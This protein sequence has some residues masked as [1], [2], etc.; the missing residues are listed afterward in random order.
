LKKYVFQAKASITEKF[1]PSFFKGSVPVK[2]GRFLK[3]APQKL[4]D[5]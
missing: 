3:K 1:L 4:S 5:N 2:S